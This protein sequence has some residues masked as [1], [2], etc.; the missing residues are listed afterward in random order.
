MRTK[1]RNYEIAAG[2]AIALS[3]SAMPMID[4]DD[5]ELAAVIA[6]LKEKLEDEHFPHAPLRSALAKLEPAS[7]RAERV[8]KYVILSAGT[9]AFI[10]MLVAYVDYLVR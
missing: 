9:A 2:Q 7:A 6:A 3:S 8:L 10:A 4:F 5:E 1:L